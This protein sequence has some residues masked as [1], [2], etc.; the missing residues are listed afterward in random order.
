MRIPE[1]SQSTVVSINNYYN[2]GLR[3]KGK[4][5]WITTLVELGNKFFPWNETHPLGNKMVESARNWFIQSGLI[6]ESNKQITPLVELFR[7]KGGEDLTGWDFIWTSL[8]NNSSLIKWFV[9]ATNIGV[10]NTVQSMTTLIANDF[11]NLGSSP[12]NGGMAALKDLLSKSPLSG[13]DAV[14]TI[15][16]KGRTVTS[17]TRQVHE[18]SN[19]VLLYGLYLIAHKANRSSFSVRELMTSE[20]DSSF[21]S[22]MVAFGI[23]PET[24]KRQCEG[25]R[26]KYPDYI[27]TTF[28]F[29]NDGVDVHPDKYSIDDILRL[30]LEQTEY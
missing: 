24:F 20:L 3:E 30:A 25:L 8:V 26:S 14:T 28:T 7:I 18:V 29:G 1:K 5:R 22:P 13:V 15:E 6:Y 4:D 17:I 11:P 2:F 27:S 21:V 9:N 10:T 16:M 19:L 23:S 12:I